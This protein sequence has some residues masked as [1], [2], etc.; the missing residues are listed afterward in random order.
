MTTIQR[1]MYVCMNTYM[2]NVGVSLCCG[3][4][5]LWVEKVVDMCDVADGANADRF[6]VAELGQGDGVGRAFTAD[7]LQGTG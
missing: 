3:G 5:G 2:L 7:H 6:G 4:C 1:T